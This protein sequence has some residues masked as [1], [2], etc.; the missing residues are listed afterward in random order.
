MQ[1]CVLCDA[2]P[3]RL[4]LQLLVLQL[5]RLLESPLQHEFECQH[6]YIIIMII[7]IISCSNCLMH[8]T[9]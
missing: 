1:A 5:H 3:A 8:V 7:I 2:L 9:V 6:Q 4:G